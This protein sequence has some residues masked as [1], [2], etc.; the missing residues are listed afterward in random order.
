MCAGIVIAARE[1]ACRRPLKRRWAALIFGFTIAAAA[2]ALATTS[3]TR[4][5]QSLNCSWHPPSPGALIPGCCHTDTAADT[6]PQQ[7]RFPLEPLPVWLA[8][9]AVFVTRSATAPPGPHDNRGNLTN[10][11]PGLRLPLLSGRHYGSPGSAAS[12]EAGDLRLHQE[13]DGQD[14]GLHV[15]ADRTHRAAQASRPEPS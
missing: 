7:T 14:A 8:A 4:V 15:G 6:T 9:H 13:R 10:L 5:Q 2:G 1:R 12:V 11:S 3:A